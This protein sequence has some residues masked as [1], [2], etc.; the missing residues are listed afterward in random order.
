MLINIAS[1][2][3]C[4]FYPFAW[5]PSVDV[6]LPDRGDDEKIEHYAERI[7]SEKVNVFKTGLSK[8]VNN[9]QRKGECL[10]FSMPEFYWNL[11]PYA[12]WSK[13][14]V[15]GAAEYYMDHIPDI[16]TRVIE[17]YPVGD[18]GKIIL[19]CG[20]AGTLIETE[21]N[22]DAINYLLAIDNFNFNAD[23]THCLSMWPKTQVATYD[24]GY[25]GGEQEVMHFF[26]GM[27]GHPLGL[28]V[29]G[30]GTSVAEH[31]TNPGYGPTFDNDILPDVPFAISLCADYAKDDDFR[32]EEWMDKKPKIHFLI[33]SG[34][35]LSASREYGPSVQY[36]IRNDGY[37]GTLEKPH[38]GGCDVMVVES[39]HIT[40]GIS[41][42]SVEDDVYFYELEVV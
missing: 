2:N 30:Q 8:A 41:P 33:A 17:D 29:N 39:G 10:F 22:Y 18:F 23:G 4:T 38:A 35:G 6:E 42:L 37:G 7:F 13:E 12:F 21:K 3:V 26:M 14:D 20:S 19:L 1:L 40:R 34:M 28:N 5:S 31:N 24:Y 36:A 25:S 9:S 15:A 16:I 11:S 32:K 27:P